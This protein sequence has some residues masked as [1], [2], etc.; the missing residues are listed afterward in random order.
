MG[1]H[2]TVT[3]IYSGAV[4]NLVTADTQTAVIPANDV[5]SVAF[6]NDYNNTNKGGGAVTNQFDYGEDNNWGWTQI[7][8]DE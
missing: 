3:E 7:S 2:V 8:D 6:T 4:Y 5:V 1:A